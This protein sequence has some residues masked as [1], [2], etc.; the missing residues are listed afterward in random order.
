MY[1]KSANFS[2]LSV[3]IVQ[4]RTQLNLLNVDIF[5]PDYS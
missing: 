5:I 2:Y 3:N 4:K 1:A